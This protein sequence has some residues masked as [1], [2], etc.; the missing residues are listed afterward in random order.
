MKQILV[1][2]NVIISFLTDR[3]ARQR[4]KAVLVWPAG[5]SWA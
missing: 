5:R 2:A 3:N 1:D 4:E